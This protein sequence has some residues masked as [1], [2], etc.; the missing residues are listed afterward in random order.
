MKPPNMTLQQALAIAER[1]ASHTR[2]CEMDAELKPS[3]SNLSRI[4][5]ANEAEEKAWQRA[6]A[7]EDSP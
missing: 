7:L 6:E 2:R 1:A 5:R 4:K 3:L